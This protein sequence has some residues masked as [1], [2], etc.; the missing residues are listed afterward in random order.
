VVDGVRRGWVKKFRTLEEAEGDLWVM[1]PDQ[2]YYRRVLSLL[3]AFPRTPSPR[4]IFKYQTL[5]E[6][7]RERE[8]WSRG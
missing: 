1:E 5:E 3:D 7:Q 6:A 8:R 4:G 2:S